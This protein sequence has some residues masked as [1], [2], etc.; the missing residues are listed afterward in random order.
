MNKMIAV[1]GFVALVLAANSQAG[2]TYKLVTK[3]EGGGRT[4]DAQNSVV[5]AQVEGDKARMEFSES[6]NPVMGKGNYILTQ[7]AGKTMYMVK[8]DEKTYM[9]WDL[10]AMM[11]MAGAAMKMMGGFMQ[12]EFSDPKIEKLADEAGEPILG[13]PTRHYKFRTTFTT[14]MTMMG[15]KSSTTTV[16]EEDVWTT[17]KVTD[18]GFGA[19]LRKTPPSLGNEQLD[20]LIKAEM[21]KVE[22]FPLRKIMVNT[23]TDPSGKEQKS[24]VTAEVTELNQTTI[25]DSQFALPTGYKE[26]AM[27]L[28]GDAKTEGDKGDKGDQPAL[29]AAFMK[30]MQQR[31]QK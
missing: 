17:T 11:G 16:K 26:T 21:S 8:P 9:K 6:K 12:M 10:E 1:G 4:A 18:A 2:Y 19:W 31:Q 24:K 7:D 28:G 27:D 29:P 22:G 23:V 25:P 20:K 14:T 3:A 30:M 15:R 13:Y 5:Q